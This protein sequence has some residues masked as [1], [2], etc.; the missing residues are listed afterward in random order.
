MVFPQKIPSTFTM[1]CFFDQLD[2]NVLSFIFL[3]LYALFTFPLTHLLFLFLLFFEDQQTDTRFD[4][5]SN[6][7]PD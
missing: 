1:T 3:S 4:G 5:L 6:N 2:T 7:F